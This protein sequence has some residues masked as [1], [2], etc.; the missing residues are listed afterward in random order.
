[1]TTTLLVAN[2]GEI[3]CR[4]I[5]AARQLSLRTVAV[6]SEA[7][8]ELP[9][10][11][12]ADEAVLLGPARAADSYLRADKLLDAAR[13]TGATLVH[14]G[15]GFLSENMAFAQAC[16]AAGITFVGPRPEVIR[17]MGDKDQA[18]QAAA[19]AGVPVLPGTGKLDPHDAAGIVA[20]GEKTGFPLLVKAAA[21]GGGIGMRSVA[22]PTDL[23]AAVQ[24]T[25]GMAQKAFGDGSV[26]LER[27]VERARHV[28]I[29]LFGFGDGTAIHLFERD[30]SLQRR[31]QKVV[32]E[33]R[34]PGIP[35]AVRQ[36]IG[37]AAVALACACNYQ[38]A[39]T[40]E[41]L[42]DTRSQEFF[43]LEMNT[44]I[45][46]EHPVTEMITGVDLVGAQLRL[47]LGERLQDEL[48]QSRITSSG[49]AVEVR[50]YAENPAKNFLPCPGLLTEFRLPEGDGIRV[51]TG[52][53][54]G[55][56]VTPFY[57]P[58]V[59]KLIAH[60]RDREHAIERMLGALGGLRIGGITHN[61]A[62]LQAVLRHPAFRAGELHTGFLGAAHATLL[63]A[64]GG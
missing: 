64:S 6:H 21:G 1:M 19:R 15:Y 25:S 45:Q 27:Y 23:V 58:M 47:A 40:V 31:H 30:C 61:A 26:Y 60:G 35:E 10:V 46:V 50:I 22:G 8:A 42:Y 33:A 3:A 49:H 18:R 32:E 59:M 4:V 17:L 56:K 44:R 9:H 43:F 53:R 14:P 7:D 28:E 37:A 41:F 20:A 39:G 5:R 11:A 54:E 24:A 48:A 51:D 16:E 36:R 52:Y 63:A 57:D 38:G 34:A 29:Q 2:R 12:L 62:Y 13:Q 55:N